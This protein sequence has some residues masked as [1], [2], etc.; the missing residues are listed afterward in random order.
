MLKNILLTLVPS[1]L[2]TAAILHPNINAK[3]TAIVC[4]RGVDVVQRSESDWWEESRE[5]KVV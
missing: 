5:S 1:D 4:T 2:S 3:K